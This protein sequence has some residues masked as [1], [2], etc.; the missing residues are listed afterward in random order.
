VERIGLTAVW[1]RRLR[2][3]M[4]VLLAACA[5]A[6]LTYTWEA[7]W[8]GNVVRA[9]LGAASTFVIL[10]GGALG[11]GLLQLAMVVLR[12]ERR[13]ERLERGL[14][15]FRGGLVEQGERLDGLAESVQ[16][17]RA[18]QEQAVDEL[19]KQA[20]ER[21]G[22]VAARAEG[23]SARL[24]TFSNLHGEQSERLERRVAGLE[25]AVRRQVAAA[26]AAKIDDGFAAHWASAETPPGERTVAAYQHL[27]DHGAGGD[28]SAMHGGVDLATDKR[29]LREEFAGLIYRRDYAGALSKGDEIATRYPD[30][31]AATDFRRVRPHLMRR[32]RLAGAVEADGSH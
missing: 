4:Y 6:G 32:I 10:A 8:Q 20:D 9:L 28:S 5:V 22:R 2:R 1:V 21:L 19:A 7:A 12:S 3:W 29:R 31:T 13:L 16:Q 17:A 14:G 25:S 27:V 24:E 18:L 30:S 11:T 15:G 23:I 26:D